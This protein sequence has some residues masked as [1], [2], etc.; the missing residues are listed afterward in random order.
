M[1]AGP[2]HAV[3]GAVLGLIALGG[4][5]L[6]MSRGAALVFDLSWVGCL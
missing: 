4:L 5:A 2:Q 3:A 1:R 6:W